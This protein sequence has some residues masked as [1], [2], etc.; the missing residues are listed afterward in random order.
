[1][2]HVSTISLRSPIDSHSSGLLTMIPIKIE[3]REHGWILCYQPLRRVGNVINAPVF[4]FFYFI[5]LTVE[6]LKSFKDTTYRP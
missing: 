2:K 6:K 4:L 3:R 5:R 1:M